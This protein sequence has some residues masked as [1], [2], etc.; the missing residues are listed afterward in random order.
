MN[1]TKKPWQS[2]TIIASGV[3]FV[4]AGLNLFVGYDLEEAEVTNAILQIIQGIAFL[5]A[6]WGRL[7]AHA[8]LV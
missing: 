3:G 6:I 2:K 1:S 4:A 5:G 8:R 7:L